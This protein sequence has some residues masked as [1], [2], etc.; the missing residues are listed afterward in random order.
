M[1]TSI[2]L[3]FNLFKI[4]VV[5]MTRLIWPV[6]LKIKIKGKKNLRKK[7]KTSNNLVN[8]STILFYF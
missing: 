4:L 3:L 6:K 7:M 5:N 8:L 1:I 2:K